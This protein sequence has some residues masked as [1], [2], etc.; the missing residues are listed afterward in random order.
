MAL[1]NRIHLYPQSHSISHNLQ[2]SSNDYYFTLSQMMMDH[3]DIISKLNVLEF[4]LEMYQEYL[5]NI[6]FG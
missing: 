3:Y 2:G 5:V 6:T 4:L 1:Y